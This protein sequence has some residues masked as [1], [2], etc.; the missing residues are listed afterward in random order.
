MWRAKKN[1]LMGI[2][3]FGA[4]AGFMLPLAEAKFVVE[5]KV[6]TGKVVRVHANQSI[7]IDHNSL[8]YPSRKGLQVKGLQ[9]GESVSLKYYEDQG[10]KKFVE[11]AKGKNSIKP[12]EIIKSRSLNKVY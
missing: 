11:Y 10:R 12:P 4:L 5:M 9:V 3:M 7:E 6:V 2:V 1:I 8:Y